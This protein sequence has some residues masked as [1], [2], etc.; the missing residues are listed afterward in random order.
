MYV[1]VYSF[2]HTVVFF[3]VLSVMVN[4]RN[5]PH[6]PRFDLSF[7]VFSVQLGTWCLVYTCIL[8]YKHHFSRT[9]SSDGSTCIGFKRR[10]DVALKC[11]HL[12]S[13]V[14][15]SKGHAYGLPWLWPPRKKHR[16][17]GML[18]RSTNCNHMKAFVPT[19]CQDELIMDGNV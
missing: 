19:V 16:P 7:V 9:I 2:Y 14:T 15:L 17:S 8:G 4:L 18:I 6:F 10:E 3:P 13:D 12:V 5:G 1:N 11:R